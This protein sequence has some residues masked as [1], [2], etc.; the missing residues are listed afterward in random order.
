MSAMLAITKHGVCVCVNRTMFSQFHN[1]RHG[2]G[3]Y[4]H[5]RQHKVPSSKEKL[6]RDVTPDGTAIH[7]FAKD[8][9]KFSFCPVKSNLQ[10][11]ITL[12]FSEYFKIN[13]F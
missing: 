4:L 7:I 13:G 8:S 1:G 2:R 6:E 12:N 11:K 3:T 9:L 10:I 5:Y